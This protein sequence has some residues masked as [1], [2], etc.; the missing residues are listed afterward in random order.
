MHD[1]AQG[2]PFTLPRD[3]PPGPPFLRGRVLA[4]ET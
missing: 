2:K 3:P 1:F 4:R